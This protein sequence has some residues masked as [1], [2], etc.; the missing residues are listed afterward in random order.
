MACV[1]RA[2][3]SIFCIFDVLLGSQIKIQK[4]NIAIRARTMTSCS[5]RSKGLRLS[6]FVFICLSFLSGCCVAVGSGLDDA[7]LPNTQYD[8]VSRSNIKDTSWYQNDNMLFEKQQHHQWRSPSP[9]S[10]SLSLL[11][12]TRIRHRNP[13]RLYWWFIPVLSCVISYGGFGWTSRWFHD[14]VQWASSNTWIPK[15]GEAV[16]LQTN[17]VVRSMLM[18]AFVSEFQ[19]SLSHRHFRTLLIY[20]WI[21]PSGEWSRYVPFHLLFL[22]RLPLCPYTS[23]H[24]STDPIVIT[25]I[26]VLFAS[27]VGLTVSNLHSR[28]VDIHKSL[29]MEVHYLRELQQLVH[30]SLQHH[31]DQPRIEACVE[32]HIQLLLSRRY[33]TVKNSSSSSRRTDDNNTDTADDCCA[34]TYIESS[35]PALL[36]YPEL[37]SLARNIMHQRAERWMALQT[38]PFP[39]AHYATLTVLALSIVISFLVATAQAEFIF[40]T[41]LPVRLLW[42]VLMT[43]FTALGV[44][45]L[46]L[47]QPFDGFYHIEL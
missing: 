14:L 47:A 23:H 21:D 26:S 40:L 46:D 35:L 13:N 41:G 32:E 36:F 11:S 29:I 4:V 6:S 18:C 37:A 20:G 2:P 42:S 10:S 17:V 7:K 31:P 19:P 38:A 43:S 3:T 8:A 22:S 25:S 39:M 5:T 33:A 1:S 27:L 16:N 24:L 44:V 12:T 15:T 45:C 9:S 28:Q 30:H 34:H